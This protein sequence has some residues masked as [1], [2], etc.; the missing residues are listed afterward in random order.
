MDDGKNIFSPSFITRTLR[1]Q[2]LSLKTKFGQNLLINRD[3][4][5]RILQY[6][7]LRKNSTVLEIGPGLGALTFFLAERVKQVISV[8]IDGGLARYLKEKTHKL[9]LKNIELI[10]GDFLRL[11]PD[12]IYADISD[13]GIPGKVVSN[14]PYNIALKAILKIIDEYESVDE[15]VGTVQNEIAK[16]IVSKP[17]EKNYSYISVY[18]QFLANS[19]IIKKNISPNNFFPAPEVESAIIRV[20]R[21]KQELPVKK[22]LFKKIVKAGFSNR[23][24]NLVN[25]LLSADIGMKKSALQTIIRHHF[26]NIKIRAEQLS[27]M[28]FIELTKGLNQ[29]IRK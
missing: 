16:R 7:E 28:D 11:H 8:E 29:F 6:S 15:V 21:V 1:E 20:S 2:S 14:F 9:G 19:T 25:N 23:R 27:V 12:D 24:K 3:L 13:G 22:N 17:G 26:H 10:N 5:L 18:L 4:A